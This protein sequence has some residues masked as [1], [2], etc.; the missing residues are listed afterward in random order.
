MHEHAFQAS[1]GV[2][3]VSEFTIPI[4]TGIPAGSDQ[5]PCSVVLPQGSPTMMYVHNESPSWPNQLVEGA[6]HGA[7]IRISVNHSKSA[8]QTY[9]M[10]SS[11][12][13]KAV[14]FDQICLNR[15]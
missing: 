9:R 15:K 3:R 12:F 13:G 4:A 14:Q 8:E 6:Q 5:L 1:I 11:L 10:I 7:S 2:R